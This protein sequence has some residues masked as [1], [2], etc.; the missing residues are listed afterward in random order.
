MISFF[1]EDVLKLG[2]VR[3]V[4]ITLRGVPP[5]TSKKRRGGVPPTVVEQKPLIELLMDD[6]TL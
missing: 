1:I 6:Y 2:L 4:S 5:V 3:R